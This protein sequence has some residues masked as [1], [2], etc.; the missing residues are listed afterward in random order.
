MSDRVPLAR[1][2]RGRALG[3]LAAGQAVRT[4]SSR[5][6]MIGRSEQARELLAE[7]ST[8]QA[9]D[10][11]VTVLGSLKGSAM[12]LG[13]LLSMLEVDM[14]PEAIAND[15]GRSWPGCAIRPHVNRSR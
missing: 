6:S 15:S 8:L 7:R 2:N 14:V 3:K 4:A 13:Q 11:L 12:K 9:A 10:Q 5:L 1:I